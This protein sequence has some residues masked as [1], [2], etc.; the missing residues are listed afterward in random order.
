MLTTP[1]VLVALTILKIVPSPF[2]ALVL[3][4]LSHFLIDF[5]VPHWNPHIFTELKKDGHISIKSIQVILID[6][7]IA[8]GVLGLLILRVWPD[9]WQSLMLVVAA[10]VS[11]LPDFIEIPHYFLGWKNKLMTNY[12]TFQHKHQSNGTFFLG[13]ATQLIV[14]AACLKQLF[15]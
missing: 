6:G 11:V 14:I 8:L 3:I 13:V 7:F 2:W 12:V 5:C 1:H 10:F 15:F 4:L 9:L